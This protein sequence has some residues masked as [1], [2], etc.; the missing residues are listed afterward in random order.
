MKESIAKNIFAAALCGLVLT[1]A[2]AADKDRS[3]V[4]VAG[5]VPLGVTVA[6]TALITT[7]WRAGK[8]IG[9]E[10]YND[11]N[12]KVGKVDDLIITPDGT[13]SI[14]IVEVGGFLG[15]GKH[16]VAIPVRQFSQIAPKAIL[17]KATKDTLKKMPEFKYAT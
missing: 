8:L 7:G 1:S 14:A 11:A 15:I 6:E 10:V 3:P 17:P 12:E 16:L 2:I 13:L 4:P 9:T 5:V